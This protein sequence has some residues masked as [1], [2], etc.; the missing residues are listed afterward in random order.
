MAKKATTED[1]MFMTTAGGA[2]S[3]ASPAAK[4]SPAPGPD[5]KPLV[6]TELRAENF[7]RLSV[8]QVKPDGS[9]VQITGKNA[10]GKSSVLDAIEAALGGNARVPGEAV[11]RGHDKG[12]VSLDFGEF[13]VRRTMTKGGGGGLTITAADG[14]N[15][16]SPQ[17]LLDGFLGAL[18]FDP[19]AFVAMKPKEQRDTL[20]GVMGI[21]DR[22]ADIEAKKKAAMDQRVLVGREVS[23][24]EGALA[25][26]PNVPSDTPDAELSAADVAGQ[27]QAQGEKVAKARQWLSAKTTEVAN[28]TASIARLEAELAQAREALAKAQGELAEH[29]PNAER[30]IN[31][32]NP[33]ALRAKLT[34]IE[35]TNAAVRAKRERAR[36]AAEL[37]KAQE[38]YRRHNSAVGDADVAMSMMLE[39][40]EMPFKGLSFN[41]K[42]LLLDR[43]PFSQASTA[44]QIQASVLI[45]LWSNPRIR[46]MLVREGSFLDSTQREILARTAEQ[47]GAQVWMERV[48][49]GEAGVGIV[50]EDGHVRAEGGES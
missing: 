21:T 46:V 22:L 1:P 32:H 39:G 23:R 19:L 45:G 20:L 3:T 37:A 26:L 41:D 27:M 8:V 28:L 13:K 36:V 6:I 43:V 16:K 5:E 38:E 47:H 10:Q 2:A 29:G 12:E 24:L 30:V 18:S 48:T 42:E 40:A 9:L 49:D 31:G 50:I 33:E 34:E 14:A 25:T 17:T 15:I 44:Q 35:S 7:K 4:A 11:R